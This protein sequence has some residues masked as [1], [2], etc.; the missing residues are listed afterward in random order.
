MRQAV[1][2]H[3]RNATTTSAM[4][5]HPLRV[6]ILEVL[7]ER[8]LSP[9][10]FYREGLAPGYGLSHVAHHFKELRLGGCLKIVKRIRRRGSVESIHRGVARAFF[11]DEDWTEL[12]PEERTAVSRTMLRGLIARA[13]GAMLAQ[14]FDRRLDR[15]LTWIAM[16]LDEQGWSELTELQANTYYR[17]E[18]IRTDAAS[19]IA[20]KESE[21]T[22]ATFG[23]LAFESPPITAS[24]Q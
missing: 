9:V 11:S 22:P 17:A 19:R 24:P 4:L 7:N 10:Q 15:H 12:S 16:D 3:G 8:D 1:Q 14:T 6:R 18:E 23:A 13:D 5:R 21:S 20:E 2:E